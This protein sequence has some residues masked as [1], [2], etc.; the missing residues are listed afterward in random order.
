MYQNESRFSFLAWVPLYMTVQPSLPC[1]PVDYYHTNKKINKQAVE[2]PEAY[3]FVSFRPSRGAPGFCQSESGSRPASS[4]SRAAAGGRRVPLP[5]YR[6]CATQS[7]SKGDTA[8]SWP[9]SWRSFVYFHFGLSSRYF[10]RPILVFSLD[11]FY[12]RE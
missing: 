9:R 12:V 2:G 3:P 8:R 4:P 5:A 11:I 7:K 1:I 10:L 6:C